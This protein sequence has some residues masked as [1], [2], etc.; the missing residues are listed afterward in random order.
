MNNSIIAHFSRDQNY[1]NPAIVIYSLVGNDVC[2]GLVF[3]IFDENLSINFFSF[4]SDP[5]TLVGFTRPDVFYKNIVDSMEYL[6][7]KLPNGSH[8]LLTGLGN[9]SYLYGLL[10]DRIHP[11]GRL[12]NDITYRDFYS[13]LSCLQ[14]EEIINRYNFNS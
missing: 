1:D 4:L 10:A 2:N 7:E 9:G 3:R 5:D 11:L 12:R 14:V 6:D 13:Y 8:V